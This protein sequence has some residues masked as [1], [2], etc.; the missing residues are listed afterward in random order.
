[1][2]PPPCPA[3]PCLDSIVTTIIVAIST[4]RAA[5]R[6]IQTLP[7]L[8]PPSGEESESRLVRVEVLKAKT[9]H[10]ERCRLRVQQPRKN[11][12]LSEVPIASHAH[13]P[14]PLKDDRCPFFR[15]P[16]YGYA[17][18]A[19]RFWGAL[20]GDELALDQAGAPVIDGRGCV[21]LGFAQRLSDGA[22]LRVCQLSPPLFSSSSLCGLMP[23]A[24][25]VMSSAPICLL[26]RCPG[27]QGLR[28][29]HGRLGVMQGRR[30]RGFKRHKFQAVSSATAAPLPRTRRGRRAPRARVDQDNVSRRPSVEAR[31][32]ACACRAQKIRE[33]SSRIGGRT[34]RSGG[35]RAPRVL[36]GRSNVLRVCLSAARAARGARPDN[37]RDRTG[38]QGRACE[39]AGHWSERRPGGRT[40]KMKHR[41]ECAEGDHGIMHHGDMHRGLVEGCKRE[42]RDENEAHV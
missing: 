15:M 17:Q 22:F 25:R 37:A 31:A 20:L 42:D 27:R 35:N 4:C 1:M 12:R 2:T 29:P 14:V 26:W 9:M 33:I 18:H 38:P 36:S 34:R 10:V 13:I 3:R 40:G 30:H 39:G 28:A 6:Q 8:R 7:V 23:L 41:H 11:S 24:R 16:S 32:V 21:A 19:P 5:P